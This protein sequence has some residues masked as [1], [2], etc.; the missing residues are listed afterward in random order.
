MILN[1]FSNGGTI[2]RTFERDGARW[3]VL[4][5]L[6]P[7]LGIAAR[8]AAVHLEDYECTAV[9]LRAAKGEREIVL[10]VNVPGLHT[11]LSRGRGQPRARAFKR[12]MVMDALPM[13]PSGAEAVLPRSPD[14]IVL[15]PPEPG[16]GLTSTTEIADAIGH[17]PNTLGR[18]AGHLKTPEHGEF[19]PAA[20]HH[21]GVA[22]QQ[23]W[24][25]E[26]GRHAVLKEFYWPHVRESFWCR[27]LAG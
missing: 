23:W 15:L 9:A 27:V 1:C 2:V 8:E 24:W 22:V 20:A 3:F 10:A 4:P 17:A 26:E 5:D 11:V 6:C 14:E 12:W 21:S 19:R 25:N 7:P 18:L 13:M 16:E